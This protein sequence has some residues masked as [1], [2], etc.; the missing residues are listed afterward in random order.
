MDQVTHRSLAAGKETAG[1]NT[2]YITLGREAA[3]ATIPGSEQRISPSLR[4]HVPQ[5]TRRITEALEVGRAR[6]VG[7]REEQI[8]HRL[9]AVLHVAP[10]LQ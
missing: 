4:L 3:M 6:L 1:G 2:F 5:P 8:A 10:G 7:E 9:A